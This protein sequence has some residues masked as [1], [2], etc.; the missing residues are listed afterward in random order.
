MTKLLSE[1]DLIRADGSLNRAAFEGI[2][3]VRTEYEINL[4][5]CVDNGIRPPRH[6]NLANVAAWRAA[7]V[8]LLHLDTLSDREQADIENRV[9]DQTMDAYRV[10]AEGRIAR[11]AIAELPAHERLARQ[12]DLKAALAESAIPARPHEGRRHRAAAAGL[13][14]RAGAAA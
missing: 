1:R 7:Q 4:A 9:R 11:A 8:A 5:L 10:Q 12:H 14:H 3:A 6:I 13:R 2:V